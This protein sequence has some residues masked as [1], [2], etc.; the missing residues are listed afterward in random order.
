MTHIFQISVKPGLVPRTESCFPKHIQIISDKEPENDGGLQAYKQQPESRVEIAASRL[1]G[2]SDEDFEARIQYEIERELLRI[3]VLTGVFYSATVVDV[4][5]M[6]SRN[7]SI[8]VS[9]GWLPRVLDP[10][11]AG[12]PQSWTGALETKLMLWRRVLEDKGDPMLGYAYLYMICEVDGFVEWDYESRIG[13]TA[14]QEIRLI[15]NLLLH[16]SEPN[17]SV[18]AYCELHNMDAKRSPREVVIHKQHAR[19][20][21]HAL[22]S[23]IRKTLLEDIGVPPN[24]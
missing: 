13:P 6:I 7:R 16:S 4:D 21:L 12:K 20:R 1:T 17:A 15:R 18:V 24:Q 8:K 5:P 14:S 9:T 19:D 2:E 10:S 11:S 22:L 3:S 23:E